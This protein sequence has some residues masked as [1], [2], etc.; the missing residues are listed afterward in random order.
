ML[1]VFC[2]LSSVVYDEEVT[3]YLVW[4]QNEKVCIASVGEPTQA[5]P[6][7]EEYSQVSF[8]INQF[9]T[10]DGLLVYKY[11]PWTNPEVIYCSLE[12]YTIDFIYPELNGSYIVND[13]VRI[14]ECG[15]GLPFGP[16][17][18][19]APC[20]VLEVV[21]WFSLIK[22]NYSW[23]MGVGNLAVVVGSGTWAAVEFPQIGRKSWLGTL[24]FMSKD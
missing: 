7:F 8:S 5:D 1:C 9:G 6:A 12:Q 21:E 16:L 4:F 2:L 18:V 10:Y 23:K 13:P 3:S 14:F 15:M 17:Q 20:M 11:G 24:E 22:V 19:N